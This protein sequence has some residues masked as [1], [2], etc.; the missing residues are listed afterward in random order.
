MSL[1]PPRHLPVLTVAPAPPVPLPP[2]VAA[3]PLRMGEVLDP[4]TLAPTD[5]EFW[6][7]PDHVAVHM[8]VLGNSGSGKSK[9]LELFLRQRLLTGQPFALWDPHGDLAK[10]LLAFV[11][12]R[13]AHPDVRDDS[14]WRKVHYLSLD[15]EAVFAYDPVA[16]AP[17]RRA[18]GDY[19]YF[20]W[21]KTRID[22][23]VRSVLRRVSEASQDVMVRLKR[24]LK[25]IFHA[26]LVALDDRNT[27]VG[28]DK[29]L[30]F[31]DPQSTEF[32]T[33]YARVA[34]HLPVRYRRNFE[35]LIATKRPQ[36]QEK[37]V[38]STINK[39]EELLSPLTEAVYG[40]RRP[41]VD[42]RGIVGRGEFL[43]IDLKENAHFS[44]DEKVTLGG[45]LLV[46]VLA[47]KEAEEDL[48][49]DE[50]REYLVA[51]DEAGE[52]LGDDLK[53]W[54][55]STRK[56][57][58]PIVLGGQGLESFARGDLDVAADVLTNCGTVV[59]FQNTWAEDKQVLADR[60]FAG[61]VDFEPRVV[62]V[63]RQRGFIPLR[64]DE[65][66]E[67]SGAQDSWNRA[68]TVTESRSHSD[69]VGEA[70][71]LT[72]QWSQGTSAGSGVVRRRGPHAD[73]HA[74]TRSKSLS[75]TDQ[76]GG[77][78]ATSSN[79]GATDTSGTARAEQEGRGGSTS[80]SVTIA[81][82]LMLLSNVVSEFEEDGSLRAGPV[83]QQEARFCQLIHTLGVGIAAVAVRGRKRA[84]LARIDQVAD[85]WPTGREKVQ[86]IR[87]IRARLA[88]L[89]G[90][91]FS[92]PTETALPPASTNRMPG[93]NGELESPRRSPRR[94]GTNG[95]HGAKP[96]AF[97]DD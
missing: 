19:V 2:T 35:K 8:A 82:K 69:S 39:L 41:P 66:S 40:Q 20:Q 24:W 91:Y 3:V 48:P 17:N 95:T 7:A 26:C 34:P 64:I 47:A 21:L 59:C 96:S 56:Y 31:T 44:H 32:Q 51:I 70:L 13:K 36:D 42:V 27:H 67:S 62:E 6:L 53:R 79:T 33:L 97:G 37:W 78:Q 30:A 80:R 23:L 9:F 85:W 77:S 46:D 4:D 88:E 18:V 84:F 15:A 60:V 55:R 57:R 89:H 81:H 58:C 90:Y 50:R 72:A 94:N 29:A 76:R 16:H 38:E 74:E 92:P 1:P 93:A 11:A 73:P 54:L 86:A 49:E 68:T 22:R 61:N 71:A 45:F 43:L 10:G 25:A 63:Q 28:L 14:L 65:V 87:L 83:N 5:D 52:L 12:A 75:L